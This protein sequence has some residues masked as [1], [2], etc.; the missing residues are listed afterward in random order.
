MV[1]TAVRVRSSERRSGLVT[2]LAV[3][4]AHFDTNG[5]AV[6]G[7]PT[8]PGTHD[9]CKNKEQTKFRKTTQVDEYEDDNEAKREKKKSR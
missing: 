9:Y 5:N 3:V 2:V 8:G 1:T 7:E 4:G 6:G